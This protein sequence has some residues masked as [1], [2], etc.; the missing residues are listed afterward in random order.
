MKSIINLNQIAIVVCFISM[1]FNR[2]N[3]NMLIIL[4]A[5]AIVN[6]IL[7]LK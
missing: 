7:D 3:I 1:I 6:A 4:G 2:N 5:S